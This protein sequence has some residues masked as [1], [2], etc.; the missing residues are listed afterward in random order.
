MWMKDAI[1]K[2]AIIKDSLFML[3]NFIFIVLAPFF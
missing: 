1:E 2:L 3:F